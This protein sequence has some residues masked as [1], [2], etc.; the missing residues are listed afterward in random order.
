MYLYLHF[1]GEDGFYTLTLENI[2]TNKKRKM[3]ISRYFTSPIE[4]RV[5]PLLSHKV[6]TKLILKL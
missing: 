6:G 2:P 5:E 3:S 4:D 1:C